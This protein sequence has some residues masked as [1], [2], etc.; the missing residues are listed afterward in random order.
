MSMGS[1]MLQPPPR[2]KP[3]LTPPLTQQL[4]DASFLARSLSHLPQKSRPKRSKRHL[5][6]PTQNLVAHPGGRREFR[7]QRDHFARA[8]NGGDNAER[9]PLC[10]RARK[11]VRSRGQLSKITGSGLTFFP[12]AAGAGAAMVGGGVALG[13]LWSYPDISA[14]LG[15]SRTTHRRSAARQP[16]LKRARERETRVDRGTVASPHCEQAHLGSHRRRAH[17]A[18]HLRLNL[19]RH[20]VAVLVHL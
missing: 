9:S 1:C 6:P 17:A 15:C 14:S 7:G 19:L 5:K 12:A 10:M 2:S 3:S 8:G 16:G 18:G 11:D 13:A 20:R 4:Q